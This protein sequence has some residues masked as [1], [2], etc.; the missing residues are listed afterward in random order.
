ISHLLL[1]RVAWSQG[2]SARARAS[3][4]EAAAIQREIGDRIGLVGSLGNLTTIAL[5]QGDIAR[6]RVH[7]EESL[8]IMQSQGGPAPG[9][10]LQLAGIHQGEGNLEQAGSLL[11]EA[12]AMYRT[13]GHPAGASRPLVSL[14]HLALCRHRCHEAIT[15]CEEALALTVGEED[16][17]LYTWAR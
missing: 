12:A 10:L 14:A 15:R 6:A 11:E 7:L 5:E 2:E 16:V 1:G 8:R 13:N 9:H 4:D 17:S 3:F